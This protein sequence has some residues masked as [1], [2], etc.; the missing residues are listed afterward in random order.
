[1]PAPV[2]APFEILTADEMNKVGLWKVTSITGGNGVATLTV[3]DA[4]VSDFLNYRIIIQSGGTIAT[5]TNIRLRLGAS[6]TG[7]YSAQEYISYA[8]GQILGGDVNGAHWTSV[9][10]SN[11][12]N[13]SDGTIELY[14]PGEARRTR[15]HAMFVDQA[16][17]GGAQTSLGY[18][19]VATAYTSFQLSTASAADWTSDLTVVVYGYNPA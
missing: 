4:F 14:G 5:G 3:P 10:R 1:M 8:A 17:T 9:G 16:T 18:H 11:P 12:T 13:G 19:N 2:F 7:Y 15:L 6:S